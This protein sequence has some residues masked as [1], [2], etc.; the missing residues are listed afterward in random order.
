MANCMVLIVTDDAPTSRFWAA[1]ITET[2]CVPVIAN[3]TAHARKVL[4]ESD[5]ALVVIDAT[6]RVTSG[7]ELCALVRAQTESPILLLTPIN[8]ETHS[9][10]AY[11]AGADECIIKPISPALFLAKIR[12]WMRREKGM[13]LEV[14]KKVRVGSQVLDP[15]KQELIDGRGKR[16]RL[17]RLEFRML[18]HFARHPGQTFA[19]DE[20]VRQVWGTSTESGSVL[21]KNIIYRL[22]KKIE[23]NPIQPHLLRTVTG[24]YLFKP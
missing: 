19:A 15:V 14:L 22:R 17:S 9:L 13:P 5:P 8:N 6:K 1:C 18:Y 11:E 4:A 21:V 2:H 16:T 10:E 12:A 20:L 23:S 3:S 24:G 7:V